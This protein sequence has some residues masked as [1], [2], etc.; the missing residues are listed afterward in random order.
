VQLQPDLVEFWTMDNSQVSTLSTK[1]GLDCKS[2]EKSL[3]VKQRISILLSSLNLLW[4]LFLSLAFPPDFSN[5][6]PRN[7]HIAAPSFMLAENT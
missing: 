5:R 7:P 3:Y 1:P 6:T 4:F 2:L